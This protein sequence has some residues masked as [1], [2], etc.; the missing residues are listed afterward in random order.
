MADYSN[1]FYPGAGYGFSSDANEPTINTSYRIPAGQFG[2]PTDP[3]TANQLDAVSKKLSTGAKVIE[4]SGVSNEMFEAMP[5]QHLTEINRLKKLTGA[6]LTF[7]GPLVEPTGVTKRGWDE[8]KR[9]Q[10]ERQMWSAVKR[11]HKLDPQGNIV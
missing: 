8:S 4:V 1:I 10:A 2:L 5:E 6:E 3:R 11:S 9:D 7:H